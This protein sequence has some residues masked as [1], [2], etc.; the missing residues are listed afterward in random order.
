MP[1][2]TPPLSPTHGDGSPPRLSL[3][4]RPTTKKALPGSSSR[5]NHSLSRPSLSLSLILR[6]QNLVQ[7]AIQMAKFWVEPNRIDGLLHVLSSHLF[8]HASRH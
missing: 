6:T 2:P 4:V 8:L 5:S 7:T 1:S 3:S